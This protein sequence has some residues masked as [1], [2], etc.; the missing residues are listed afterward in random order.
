MKKTLALVLT[1]CML[2]SLPVFTAAAEENA[3]A[4]ATFSCYI[5][6]PTNCA[7]EG[8]ECLAWYQERSNTTFDFV[9]STG[10]EMLPMLLN[11]GDYPEIIV[12]NAL[13]N[14]DIV[15]YG[16]N[17]QIF[18]P[19]DEYIDEYMPNVKAYM[20]DH[21]VYA[22]NI[23]APDG[24]IYGLPGFPASFSHSSI[25]RKIWIN[26]AWLDK[27]GL[28]MPQTT[29]ELYDVLVAFRDQDPNGNGKKDEIPFT[30]CLNTWWGEAQYAMMQSFVYTETGTWMTV[31]DGQAKF[32]ANTDE[33]REGLK[34][35]NKLV[36]EGLMDP[37]A[38][39][40]D[41][42]QL[43][44]LCQNEECIVG[45]Y[46]C[47]HLTIPLN[48]EDIDRVNMYEPLVT[49]A[50]PS[51]R[52]VALFY[53]PQ[54]VSGAN[55][56]ITDACKD[57]PR[58]LQAI[59][60]LFTEEAS[61]IMNN[62]LEGDN[63]MYAEEGMIDFDGNPAKYMNPP[64]ESEKHKADVRIDYFDPFRY[65]SDTARTK[66][67]V[68]SDD[69]YKNDSASYERR[70]YEA[71]KAY[72]PYFPKETMPVIW[73]DQAVA[74][75]HVQLMVMIRD[76][77]NQAMTRFITGDMDLDTEWD[78]YVKALD[79]MNLAKYVQYYQDGIDAAKNR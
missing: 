42:D 73:A 66:Y 68:G 77:V 76:Y 1:L 34:Y 22:K 9:E 23:V 37:A 41:V 65:M 63:W 15:N 8:N 27:L 33:F 48:F 18:V 29:D 50:S 74:E 44:V 5:E 60:I 69:I 59:D 30:G 54:N 72:E 11:T 70:L 71:S 6:L 26:K 75:E 35:M 14:D 51:G 4:P 61:L 3:L 7:I 56:V 67:W 25:G 24:H 57:V 12:K 40:Q 13:S 62:G 49:P 16:V 31:E 55:F 43:S 10:D 78:S 32:V 45:A 47:G 46:A 53:D 21:P 79:D 52:R 19:I 36:A 20:A 39:T 58:A 2:L 17:N 28:A 38:F 64:V